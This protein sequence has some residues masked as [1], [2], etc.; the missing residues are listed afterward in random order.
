MVVINYH[1][2]YYYSRC[3][4]TGL[5]NLRNSVVKHPDLII[6]IS[7]A[8]MILPVCCTAAVVRMGVLQCCNDSGRYGPPLIS[9][10]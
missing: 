5:V 9:E 3:T 8:T 7:R 6:I 1:N 2:N 4:K 10:R